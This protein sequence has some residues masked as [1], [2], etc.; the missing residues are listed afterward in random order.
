[1]RIFKQDEYSTFLLYQSGSLRK[2]VDQFHITD[3]DVMVQEI[4][5]SILITSWP[6][7]LQLKDGL[8]HLG[9]L[10]II[11]NNVELLKDFFCFSPPILSPGKHVMSEVSALNEARI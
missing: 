6:A 8:R 2:A 9:V 4:R 1:M 10:E 3:K 5:D 7:I 11:R